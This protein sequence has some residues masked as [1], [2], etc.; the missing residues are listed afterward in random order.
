MCVH[1]IVVNLS[2]VTWVPVGLYW[3]LTVV[4]YFGSMHLSTRAA[5]ASRD[6]IFVGSLVKD[7][8]LGHGK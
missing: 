5:I 7:V 3:K 2:T 8:T 1:E 6:G 4:L